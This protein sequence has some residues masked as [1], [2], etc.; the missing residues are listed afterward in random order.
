MKNTQRR[1][2]KFLHYS[3]TFANLPFVQE[4]V[5]PYPNI[6]RGSKMTTKPVLIFISTELTLKE[7]QRIFSALS[8]SSLRWCEPTNLSNV[9]VYGTEIEKLVWLAGDASFS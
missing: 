6:C 4:K 3:T 5:S 7:A 9:E 8:K 1:E 2:K